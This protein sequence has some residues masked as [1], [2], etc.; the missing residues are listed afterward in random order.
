VG[1]LMPCLHVSDAQ[2]PRNY[3]RITKD[4]DEDTD[5]ND[6]RTKFGRRRHGRTPNETFLIKKNTHINIISNTNCP[7]FISNL[8]L[9]IQL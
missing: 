4:S 2:L 1:W 7:S 6:E 3:V 5:A 8:D 9:I